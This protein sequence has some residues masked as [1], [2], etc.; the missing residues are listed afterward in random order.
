MACEASESLS[1]YLHI[2][3]CAHRCSYCDFNTYTSVGE[4][5]E[6]YARALAAEVRQ[7]GGEARRP[8]HTLFFGGGTPSL[9][10]AASLA[11]ILEAVRA[12]FD[13]APQAEIS[14]EAN[15]NTVSADY[16]AQ[17][18][19]LGVNRLSFGA[20]SAVASEL[21]LLERRHE[22]A[23]VV[24]AT[25]AARRAGFDDFNIDL[26]YGVPGQTLASWQ[27]SVEAVLALEPTHVS[28]Y[29]LTVEPGTSMQRW[30][31]TGSI[32]PPDPDLAADQYT[33]AGERLAQAGYEHYEISNWALPGRRCRHNLTYWRN[34]AYLGLGAGAHGHAGGYRYAVVRRPRNYLRR[35]AHAVQEKPPFPLSSAVAEQHRLSERERI[36]DT[37]IT[38]LR[39]LDEGVDEAW[40]EATFGR[41]PAEVYG[42]TLT[43]LIDWGLLERQEGRLLLSQRGRFLSNQVFHRLV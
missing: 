43:Q 12:A 1:L 32:E 26:I 42:E 4:L 22:F 5:K 38:R 34:G 27:Q 23:T 17:L 30:L 13:V 18:R 16:L 33:W 3:F 11:T 20:Q 7:V 19:D 14:L 25:E 31:Q 39:L 40:F 28:L 9:M 15:P 29:C 21:Q 6:P 35:L 8:A 36:G 41:P 24:S 10:P 37:M 2:P